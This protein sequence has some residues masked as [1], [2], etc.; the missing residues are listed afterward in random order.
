MSCRAG[1]Q[2]SEAE[3]LSVGAGVSEVGL[4]SLVLGER[5]SG[6]SPPVSQQRHET[7]IFF[8]VGN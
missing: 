4:M 5:T 8:N 7:Q 1:T 2:T 6:L 3:A